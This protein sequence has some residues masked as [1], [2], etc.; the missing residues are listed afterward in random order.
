[1]T[2]TWSISFWLAP[3]LQLLGAF[4]LL[5]DDWEHTLF[6]LTSNLISSSTDDLSSDPLQFIIVGD[7]R[8]P[9][10]DVS[11]FRTW[12][13]KIWTGGA[14]FVYDELMENSSILTF[15]T[16]SMNKYQYLSNLATTPFCFQDVDVQSVE[17]LIFAHYARVQLHDAR[18]ADRLAQ[19]D[20][21]SARQIG[22][23]F[24]NKP[25]RTQI[26]TF[27]EHKLI[28]CPSIFKTAKTAMDEG[29]LLVCTDITHHDYHGLDRYYGMVRHGKFLVGEN[30]LGKI[31]HGLYKEM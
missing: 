21:Q 18:L 15:N 10:R 12:N 9:V 16:H 27:I 28:Q 3:L 26:Q 29:M 24:R 7:H 4:V 13:T 5:P 14:A 20:G 2:L 25:S 11:E 19:M 1:M 22:K 6:T 23:Y 8:Y 31:Y 17:S 30:L